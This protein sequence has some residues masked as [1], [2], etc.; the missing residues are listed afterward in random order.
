LEIGK[1]SSD[2]SK[3]W[4]VGFDDFGLDDDIPTQ[5]ELKEVWKH[6]F[7]RN[8]VVGINEDLPWLLES[9][10]MQMDHVITSVFQGLENEYWKIKHVD[11]D[12]FLPNIKEECKDLMPT[13]RL[14]NEAKNIALLSSYME[15][16]IPSIQ[17]IIGDI[18]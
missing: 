6:T 18:F 17:V 12:F 5:I 3:H 13:R 4:S 8:Y 2:Y 1:E 9:H 10:V 14:W 11:E 7:M 15:V 16:F